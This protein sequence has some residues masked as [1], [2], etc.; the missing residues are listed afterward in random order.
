MDRIWEA[1]LTDRGRTYVP[2]QTASAD[3]RFH[4]INDPMYS[5]LIQTPVTPA[6]VL[7]VTTSYAYDALP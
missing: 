5:V 1:W 3:P 4:R 2:D 7:D 6:Q